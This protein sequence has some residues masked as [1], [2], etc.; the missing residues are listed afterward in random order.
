MSREMAEEEID[1]RLALVAGLLELAQP[2]TMLRL[3]Y[4]RDGERVHV[5]FEGADQR[6]GAPRLK[7]QLQVAL[8]SMR[9]R[10]ML[11]GTND[12]GA[13]P[14]PSG[15]DRSFELVPRRRTLVLTPAAGFDRRAA[16]ADSANSVIVPDIPSTRIARW[17][18]FAPLLLLR[19]NALLAA[20][21]DLFIASTVCGRFVIFVLGF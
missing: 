10:G 17:L 2:G 9:S 19:H 21:V 5:A 20:E 4:S 8:E 3:V 1:E 13:A 14:Q 7:E 15:K 16:D 6:P 12:L 18:T 11:F